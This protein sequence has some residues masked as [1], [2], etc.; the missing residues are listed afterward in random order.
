MAPLRSSLNLHSG[1]NSRYQVACEETRKL[2]KPDVDNLLKA[3][4]DALTARGLEGCSQV[5]LQW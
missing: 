5:Q 1:K 3:A 2:S 4:T